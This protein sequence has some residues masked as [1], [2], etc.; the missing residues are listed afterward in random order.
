MSN[1]SYKEAMKCKSLLHFQETRQYAI[2][3]LLYLKSV[4]EQ[5]KKQDN[6]KQVMLHEF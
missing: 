4:R 2:D 1:V 3:N 5:E 6:S